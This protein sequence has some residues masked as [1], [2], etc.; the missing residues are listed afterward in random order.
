M[1][2][3]FVSLVIAN[4]NYAHYLPEAID[5]ALAAGPLVEIIVVDDGSHDTSRAVIARYRD[6]I[7]PV[8]QDNKGACAARNA[9]LAI[10][11]APY[12]KFLDADDWLAE[13]AIARQLRE[14][15]ALGAAKAC[16]FGDAIW[17]AED[18]TPL[19]GLAP[20]A[21]A[22]MVFD[23]PAIVAG[24]PLTSAPLHR[25]TDVR[26]VGGFDPLVR[27]GQEHDLHVRLALSGVVFHYR[28]GPSY[29]YRQHGGTGRISSA[30]G[31]V[32]DSVLAA[33]LRHVAEARAA[34]LMT[35]ALSEA[36]A[37]RLWRQGRETLQR[38]APETARRF[39]HEA[40]LLCPHAPAPGP[41]AYRTLVRFLGPLAAERISAA[42]V[43]LGGA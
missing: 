1:D 28:P 33:S 27:R 18:G 16:V 25:T 26:E 19:A 4:H 32:G 12:V 40:R 34:G 21:P 23:L 37:H 17:A 42:R 7:R 8:F 11:R 13:G 24:P 22:S 31:V 41:L 43:R 6:A 5:S 3:P 10:A 20:M 2:A 29:Y 30:S 38:G 35:P 14:A 15:Q 36:F 9:G 39:F